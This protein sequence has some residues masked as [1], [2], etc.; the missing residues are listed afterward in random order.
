MPHRLDRFDIRVRTIRL[1]FKGGQHPL[2]RDWSV[3]LILLLLA[4]VDQRFLIPGGIA[5][6][7]AV[8][9]P[10]GYCL[11]IQMNRFQC[12]RFVEDG[13]SESRVQSTRAVGNR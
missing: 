9:L 3:S 2:P 8:S 12:K 1:A 7:F 5:V 13:L 6:G 10:F 4:E 11:L